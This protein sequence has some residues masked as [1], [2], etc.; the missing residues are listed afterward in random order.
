MVKVTARMRVLFFKFLLLLN[1][2][3]CLS[4]DG[5]SQSGTP[6]V[7]LAEDVNAFRVEGDL[8][9]WF[10]ISTHIEKS[11]CFNIS[12]LNFG[13]PYPLFLSASVTDAEWRDG[14]VI[15]GSYLVISGAGRYY[16]DVNDVAELPEYR[17]E[18]LGFE[19]ALY[20]TS[21]EPGLSIIEQGPQEDFIR[22]QLNVTHG[23]LHEN[24]DVLS[25]F[26]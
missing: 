21:N 5:G 2:S 26:E 18:L 13:G 9:I 8:G 19:C 1:L 14:P 17:F 12:E 16:V 24:S 23:D 22:L 10:S 4:S 25:S 7:L 11:V 15:L 6:R 3:G 20:A